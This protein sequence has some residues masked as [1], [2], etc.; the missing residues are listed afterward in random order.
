MTL[1]RTTRVECT[2]QA[3]RVLVDTHQARVGVRQ[4]KHARPVHPG[5]EISVGFSA[6]ADG[7]CKPGDRAQVGGAKAAVTDIGSVVGCGVVVR[8][9]TEVRHCPP[10]DNV[11]PRVGAKV[12]CR[13]TT[14][15]R[16][17]V[18]GRARVQAETRVRRLPEGRKAKNITTKNFFIALCSTRNRIPR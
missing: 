12:W 16:G 11:G 9:S 3:K 5:G 15:A 1:V 13:T 14:A 17:N 7:I 18:C 4:R 10:R 6:G 8:R 2:D